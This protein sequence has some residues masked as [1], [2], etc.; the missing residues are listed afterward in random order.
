M[1]LNPILPLLTS[2]YTVMGW[3][4]LD[5]PK[6]RQSLVLLS[7]PEM[8]RVVRNARETQ[9]FS[10]G[11]VVAVRIVLNKSLIVIT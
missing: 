5:R 9:H 4:N 1:R 8:I 6:W 10:S 3:K 11:V 2:V 7:K